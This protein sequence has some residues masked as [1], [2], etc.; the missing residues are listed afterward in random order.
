MVC[1]TF[2]RLLNMFILSTALLYLKQQNKLPADNMHQGTNE[3]AE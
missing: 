2:A 1:G 3:S